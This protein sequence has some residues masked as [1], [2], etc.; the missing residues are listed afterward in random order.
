MEAGA[1]LCSSSNGFGGEA[2][3]MNLLSHT[4]IE[5]VMT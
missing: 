3:E 2:V 1:I 5:H 4:Y